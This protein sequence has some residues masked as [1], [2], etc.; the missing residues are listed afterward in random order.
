MGIQDRDLQRRLQRWSFASVAL[1]TVGVA[2]SVGGVFF[3]RRSVL[4]VGTLLDVC[5]RIGA[6]GCVLERRSLSSLFC[7]GRTRFWSFAG[8]RF[9]GAALSL[10]LG[11][12]VVSRGDCGGDCGGNK[13]Y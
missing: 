1:G 5:A 4:V 13:W 12:I 7:T 8:R 11:T 9:G 2:F 3:S 6:V 10:R